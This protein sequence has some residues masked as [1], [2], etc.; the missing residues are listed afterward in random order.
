EREVIVVPEPVSNS[1]I[2]SAT[3]RYFQ[4]IREIVEQLDARPP[5]VM[6]QVLIAEVS[7]DGFV[8]LGIELGLQEPMLFDRSVL[9]ET[10]AIPGFNFNNAPL[11]NSSSPASLATRS[12]VL[13]Q[14]LTNFSLGRTN[15]QQ[16]YGGFVF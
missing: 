13:S 3:P 6:I 10:V 16:G 4:D 12:N 15:G 9:G 1:L 2:V 11:G 8:E 5:M 7:L 14:G